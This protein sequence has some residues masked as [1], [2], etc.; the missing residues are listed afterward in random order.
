VLVGVGENVRVKGTGAKNVPVPVYQVQCAFPFREIADSRLYRILSRGHCLLEYR[1]RQRRRVPRG[2]LARLCLR[3]LLL[4]IQYLL[5]LYAEMSA[6]LLNVWQEA[7]KGVPTARDDSGPNER[8][9][10]DQCPTPDN[11]RGTADG[12]PRRNKG[13][14]ASR[15]KIHRARSDCMSVS[16]LIL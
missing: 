5:H 3:R 2:R 15:T 16:R 1:K 13:D 12:G 10:T 14:Q 8:P 4:R 11:R 7:I 6:K 9:S